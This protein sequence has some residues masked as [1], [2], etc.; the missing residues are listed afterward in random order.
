[1]HGHRSSHTH[2]PMYVC[3]VDFFFLVMYVGHCSERLMTNFQPKLLL[4]ISRYIPT[5]VDPLY[6]TKITLQHICLG[7]TCPHDV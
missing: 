7:P 3:R 2:T 5:N 6:R 1:M 4:Y